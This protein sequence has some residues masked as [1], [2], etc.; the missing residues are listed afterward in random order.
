MA[1]GGW[2]TFGGAFLVA[3]GGGNGNQLQ[4]SCLENPMDR[5]ASW[6]TVYGSHKVRQN[7][8]THHWWLSR[9]EL[10]CSAGAAG[11]TG[12]IPSWGRSPGGKHQNPTPVFLPWAEEHGGLQSK[13]RKEPHMTEATAHTQT[14]GSKITLELESKAKVERISVG[15]AE[16]FLG[17]FCSRMPQAQKGF[18]LM[19]ELG[20]QMQWVEQDSRDACTIRNQVRWHEWMNRVQKMRAKKQ[21]WSG[22]HESNHRSP[23]SSKGVEGRE[24]ESRMKLYKRISREEPEKGI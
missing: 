23:Q 4:Y 24:E 12:W 16:S 21:D 7:W 22:M 15:W 14:F 11:E 2:Q 8:A 1:I 20:C 5:G 3:S 19:L 6:S 13:G 18:L 9:K 10:A 17:I